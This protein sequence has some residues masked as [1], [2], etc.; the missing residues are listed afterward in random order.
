MITTAKEGGEDVDEFHEVVAFDL[1]GVT[2]PGILQRLPTP[3]FF[4]DHHVADLGQRDTNGSAGNSLIDR[5]HP[6]Y[7][8]WRRGKA[9]AALAANVD[10]G[11]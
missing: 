3:G 1:H 5:F 8:I 10:L 11:L 4:G 6:A 9:R 2:T 7:G